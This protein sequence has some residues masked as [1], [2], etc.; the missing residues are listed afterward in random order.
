[1]ETSIYSSWFRIF[2]PLHKVSYF[3]L[4]FLSSQS[5]MLWFLFFK[6]ALFLPFLKILS[7]Y[8]NYKA[9]EEKMLSQDYLLSKFSINTL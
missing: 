2:P 3:S 4:S 8:P 5:F 9:L 6:F 7:L 1:M